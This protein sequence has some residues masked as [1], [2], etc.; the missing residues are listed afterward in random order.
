VAEGVEMAKTVFESLEEKIRRTEF[1]NKE[2]YLKLVESIRT[3]FESL[4]D[5]DTND[6]RATAEKLREAAKWSEDVAKQIVE[7]EDLNRRYEEILNGREPV[8]DE[9]PD[10]LIKKQ[11]SLE[12]IENLI[13]LGS[14]DGQEEGSLLIHEDFRGERLMA[15]TELVTKFDTWD[16]AQL[17][18][19]EVG[20]VVAGGDS[21]SRDLSNSS[22][23][24]S[25]E[26]RGCTVRV[27]QDNFEDELARIPESVVLMPENIDKLAI[28]NNGDMYI[29]VLKNTS[30]TWI[31]GFETED[32]AHLLGVEIDDGKLRLPNQSYD[33]YDRLAEDP[34]LYEYLRSAKQGP[35]GHYMVTKL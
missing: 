19:A 21:E 14:L 11:E 33:L 17:A 6:L 31:V 22:L 25:I 10:L 27:I 12:R 28:V 15:L 1:A 16:E 26:Q 35:F 3:R 7:C 34:T 2:A 13:R 32:E 20:G 9:V 24:S 8:G 18:G 29:Y 23:S 30:N 5:L 4:L